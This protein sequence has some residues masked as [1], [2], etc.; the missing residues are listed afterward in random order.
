MSQHFSLSEWIEKFLIHQEIGKNKSKSTVENYKRYLLKFEK[1]LPKNIVPEDLTLDDIEKFRLSLARSISPKTK[2]NLSLKTQGF[3]L[4]AIRAF[5]KF[6]HTRD[7]ETLSAEKIDVPKS[8]ERHID[9]LSS[10]EIEE[11]IHAAQQN[12]KTGLRDSTIIMTLFSTGLRVTELCNLNREDVNGETGEF[13]VKGKGGKFRVVFLTEKAK[14]YIYEYSLLRD[15]QDS[16]ASKQKKKGAFFV[17]A[18]NRSAGKRLSR[19]D[20]SRII[21][22][23]TAMAG[24]IKKVTP[25]TLRHSFATHLLQ[26]GADLR[27]VQMMLGHSSISTT[28]IYTHFTDH[29]LKE[30]HKKFH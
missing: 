20:I 16:S 25:H 24:I 7:I 29:Q 13:A 27:S 28:Q 26:K 9:F 12:E 21:K 18:S 4:I 14:K 15:S 30:V 1:S 2:K 11:I 5:L 10:E 23:A 8:G 17:S 19:G 3:H 22:N 6:L